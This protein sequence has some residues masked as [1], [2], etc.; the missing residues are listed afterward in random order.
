M[1]IRIVHANVLDASADALILAM[2]GARRGMGGTVAHG[3]ARRWPEVFGEI[4]DQIGY[5][6]PS[7]RAVATW[8]T[9]ECPF[10]R[11]FMAATLHHLDVLADSQKAGVVASA[12][13][14]ALSL[15]VRHR[16]YAIATAVM[17]GGWRLPL[18][19][20]LG[21][22]LEASQ[23]LAREDAAVSL[24]IHVLDDA[25]VARARVVAAARGLPLGSGPALQ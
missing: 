19:R 22:M 16:P 15:A 17:T 18:A 10:L 2:D 20:A 7:G 21:T 14:E 13:G 5:P 3:F 23:F 11:V 24:A 12:L 25:A 8:P 4:E 1:P 6:V 9:S